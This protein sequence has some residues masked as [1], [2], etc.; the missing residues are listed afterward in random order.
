MDQKDFSN[1]SDLL[2]DESFV[3]WVKNTDS[4]SKKKW[5]DWLLT[6]SH[7]KDDVSLARELIVRMNFKTKYPSDENLQ[8]SFENLLLIVGNNR[9]K[10]KKGAFLSQTINFH[11]FKIAAVVAIFLV[12]FA[13]IYWIVD[14]N[15]TG[16]IVDELSIPI[17]KRANPA[18][19]KSKITLPDG[20]TAWLNAGSKLTYPEKFGEVRGVN[21]SGEAYFEITENSRRPFIVKT[22][23]SEIKVLGTEFNVNA[24]EKN[25]EEFISLIKGKVTVSMLEN[26]TSSLLL[27]GEQIVINEKKGIGRV[28]SF[29]SL[30][31]TGWKQGWLVFKNA[32]KEEMVTKLSNWY[33]VDIELLNKP[34]KEWKVNG[35]FQ[36]QTLEMVL[37]RLSFLKDFVYEIKGKTVKIRFMN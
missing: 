9:D 17:I 2:G 33:G 16:E 10:R 18:G 27:P 15:S 3:Q 4:K 8:T 13:A 7:R 36:N 37:D 34:E 31:I 29:D 5:D 11:V 21:L 32:A 1:I 22:Q 23:L 26:D 25:S 28:L 30:A 6:N 24:Y 35:Y 12:S 19:V 14:N 20:S